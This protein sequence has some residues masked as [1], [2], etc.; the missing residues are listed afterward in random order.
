M[1]VVI[2]FGRR[3]T[4]FLDNLRDRLGKPRRGEVVRHSLA[5]LSWATRNIEDGRTI[6]AVKEIEGGRREE[7]ELSNPLLDKLRARATTPSSS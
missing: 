3:A 4:R 1:S 2:E 6:V 5:V 7:I